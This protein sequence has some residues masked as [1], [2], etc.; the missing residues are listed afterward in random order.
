MAVISA[1]EYLNQVRDTLDHVF[2]AI[3]LEESRI[4]DAGRSVPD[5]IEDA[6]LRSARDY[7]YQNYTS[8][9]MSEDFDE[10]QI[11]H[12]FVQFAAP[13][14]LIAL[15]EITVGIL[16]G[17]LLQIAKQA[18]SIAHGRNG[19]DCGLGTKIGGLSMA[20]IIW[21]ARN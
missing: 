15:H 3:D 20:Q 21:D 6:D 18:I 19:R 8:M 9:E 5:D 17:T 4:S 7:F 14:R 10:R 13:A 16:Y 2:A 1:E 12:A 11:Q